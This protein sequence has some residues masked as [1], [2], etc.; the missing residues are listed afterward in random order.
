M[1]K[2]KI[3][4][5]LEK[6]GYKEIDEIEYN[7]QIKV[8][9]F[10]YVFD[11]VEL[12]ASKEYANENYDEANGEEEWYDEFFLPYLVDMASDNVRDTLEDICE[13]LELTGEFILYEPDRESYE[14]MEFILVIAEQDV[15][16]DVDEI[17]EKLEL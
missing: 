7:K 10:F 12:E 4:N 1:D 3:L 8:F 6:E 13:E 14:Q 9:N 5:M 16:F 15:E 17:V 11:E 2:Q